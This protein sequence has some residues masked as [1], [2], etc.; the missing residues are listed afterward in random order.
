MAAIVATTVKEI[1][2]LSPQMT[3]GTSS[4]TKRYAILDVNATTAAASDTLDL[5]TIAKASAI[6]GP[7]METLAGKVQHGTSASTWSGT[8]VTFVGSAVGGAYRGLWL[9]EQ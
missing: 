6:Y 8:T 7:L 5:S 2:G 1:T 4:T 9:V 3:S